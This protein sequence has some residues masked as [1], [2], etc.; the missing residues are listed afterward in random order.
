MMLDALIA[1]LQLILGKKDDITTK[2]LELQKLYP[3]GNDAWEAFLT[4]WAQNVPGSQDIQ[5]DTMVALAREA[6][7]EITSKRPGYN[8]KH[9]AFA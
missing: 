7:T 6:W 2:V 3:E 4:W 9:G 8:P 5:H 1:A